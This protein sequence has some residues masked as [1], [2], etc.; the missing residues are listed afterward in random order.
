MLLQ[1]LSSQFIISGEL[2]CSA[3]I[4]SLTT[5]FNPQLFTDSMAASI[6]AREIF[7]ADETIPIE[8]PAFKYR[9]YHDLNVIFAR[10]VANLFSM[11]NYKNDIPLLPLF[12][13]RMGAFI[14]VIL[15]APTFFGH[16]C[17]LE[18]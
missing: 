10:Q 18:D 15:P 16:L 1:I 8:S 3:P 12:R 17:A 13:M 6:S 14:S 11:K 9:R 2:K 4:V 5:A 7:L